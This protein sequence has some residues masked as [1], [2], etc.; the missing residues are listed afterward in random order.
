MIDP[1]RN[2]VNQIESGQSIVSNEQTSCNQR[3]I[4]SNQIKARLNGYFI[5]HASPECVVSGAF[6]CRSGYSQIY[7]LYMLYLA[8]HQQPG[9]GHGFTSFTVHR[10]SNR[11]SKK[12]TGTPSILWGTEAS[13]KSSNSH[14]RPFKPF[15]I[16]MVMH[17]VLR[18]YCTTT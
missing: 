6:C 11:V 1:A 10:P 12:P 7:G 3:V 15:I 14:S 4:R 5:L 9:D 13:N 2:P 18:L 16:Q 8:V 17:N